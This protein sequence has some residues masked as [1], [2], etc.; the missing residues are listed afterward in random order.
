MRRALKAIMAG[1]LL[2]AGGEA[3]QADMHGSMKD[4]EP[5]P[6]CVANWGGFYAG[7]SIGYATAA[8]DILHV[9][10]DGTALS[11]QDDDVSSDGAVGTL[12]LGYDRMV[13]GFLLG[14]FV[15]YSFGELDGSGTLTAP[16]YIEPYSLTYDNRWA[17]GARLGFSR[18]CCTLWYVTAGY[19][20]AEAEFDDTFSETLGGYFLGGGVEQQLQGGLS[21]KLEYRYE[22]L[23]DDNLFAVGGVVCGGCTQSV[24]TDPQIHTIR[25]GV[26]YK[27]GYRGSEPLPMK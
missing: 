14:A 21:L 9:I 1:L 26:N 2:V 8:S 19:T 18:S 11:I 13:G 7:A 22:D 10:D 4:A 12:T 20:Q 17:V 23:S 25:L 15:D 27:F 16:G 5:E 6:C 24:D 3:A